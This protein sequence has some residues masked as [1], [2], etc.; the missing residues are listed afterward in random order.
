MSR[1]ATKVKEILKSSGLVPNT[2]R[3]NGSGAP[4]PV[5]QISDE[6]GEPAEEKTNLWSKR[7]LKIAKRTQQ[8]LTNSVDPYVC[9]V[10][11]WDLLFGRGMKGGGPAAK[12]IKPKEELLRKLKLEKGIESGDTETV[13]VG[14][15]G[16]L[17]RYLRVNTSRISVK[18]VGR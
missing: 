18:A 12:Y 4:I 11:V 3:W 9:M 13:N 5:S 7:R 8:K 1:D 6:S 2:H 10:M 16:T 14:S 17:P 15:D